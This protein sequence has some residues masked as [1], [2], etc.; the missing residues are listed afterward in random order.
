[1]VASPGRRVTLLLC[2]PTG[3]LLGLLP[4]VDVAVPY[5]QE[6]GVVVDAVEAAFGV[7][8]TVLRLLHV[9][10]A[11]S[12]DG[13]PVT[14]LAETVDPVP[15][16]LLRAP[17]G[18]RDPL[19]SEPLR[20]AYAHPGGPSAD[21]AWAFDELAARDL[22]P[23]GTPQR[24]RQIRI[25]NLS[26]L[27][28]LPTTT[29][30][31]WLKVVPPF[32]ARE[33]AIL[34][35]LSEAG[36]PVPR[37]LASAAPRVL[38]A[39]VPGEDRYGAPPE[40]LAEMADLLAALQAAWQ[41]R[42]TDVL[43][44]GGQDRRPA[45][46]IAA[47]RAVVA[48]YRDALDD[49]R[50]GSVGG[51][52]DAAGPAALDRLVDGLEARYA[53]I[54]ACG[55]PDTLVHGDLHP[56]NVRGRPGAFRILDWGETGVGHPA[57]DLLS[58]TGGTDPATRRRLTERLACGRRDRVSARGLARAADLLAPVVPLLGVVTYQGFL[59]HI[60]PDERVYH[61]HDP[62]AALRSAATPAH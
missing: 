49:H 12:R 52:A 16:R 18:D 56:G 9:E 62:L 1:M 3:K 31:A 50:D 53:A 8:V 60:E 32:L 58:L 35:A 13:G 44:L 5:W 17:D 54:D 36:A 40:H 34:G 22:L 48:R 23:D 6:V 51:A 15:A 55:L 27:W 20:A 30:R 59:D 37:V 25:W 21:L 14:Y 46:S 47:V 7:H 24:P 57:I 41:D 26:S 42:V 43:H 11:Q 2:T 10:A 19:A 4:P 28:C 33:A 38:L 29:G 39:D 61:Q 45:A